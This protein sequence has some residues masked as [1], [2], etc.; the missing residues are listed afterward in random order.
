MGAIEI[1]CEMVRD[2]LG[3][4]DNLEV[5][6]TGKNVFCVGQE[7][8]KISSV[9]QFM[10]A[11]QKSQSK[12]VFKANAVNER[13]SRSHHVFQIK[14]D[15]FDIKNGRPVQSFLNI[16]DLAGSERQSMLDMN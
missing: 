11:I 13:S 4:G 15:T 6:G 2:L 16:V 1:Y 9:N 14:I 3:E 7:W 10:Q 12:R 5:R 8:Q